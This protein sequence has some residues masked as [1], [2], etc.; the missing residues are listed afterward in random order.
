[1][2]DC[3]HKP[4]KHK[5]QETLESLSKAEMY[6]LS[7]RVKELGFTVKQE[8]DSY[9]IYKKKNYLGKI[10][11]FGRF[12]VSSIAKEDYLEKLTPILE[13]YDIPINYLCQMSSEPEL[14]P[15]LDM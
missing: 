11:Y 13:E 14:G 10:D 3:V 9:D 2:T 7:L 15:D 4:W 12:A 8:G 5:K 1:M 6:T